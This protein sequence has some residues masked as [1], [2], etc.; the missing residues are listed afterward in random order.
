ML[1][2]RLEV[3]DGLLSGAMVQHPPR[4]QE[5][6]AVKQPEYGVP[7]LVDGEDDCFS[8]L[9]HPEWRVKSNRGVS[10]KSPFS[11]QTENLQGQLR[12]VKGN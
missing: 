2:D 4:S 3:G 8:L 12:L 7:W 9:C 10:C 5:R 1:T 6:Q 11:I